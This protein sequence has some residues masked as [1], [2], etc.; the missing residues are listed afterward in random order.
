M[1]GINRPGG[2]AIPGNLATAEATAADIKLQPEAEPRG[3]TLTI[4][5]TGF[6]VGDA[7][8]D[9]CLPDS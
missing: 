6:L 2:Q 9:K 3:I 5:Q 4:H 1:N 7:T 8:F